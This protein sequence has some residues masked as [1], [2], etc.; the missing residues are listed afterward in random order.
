MARF[1][2]VSSIPAHAAFA[3]IALIGVMAFG[4]WEIAGTLRDPALH[5]IPATF[6]D[7]RKGITTAKV[8]R[9]IEKRLPSREV[10]AT[11]SSVMRYMLGRGGGSEV[12]VGRDG[13]LFLADELRFHVDADREIEGRMEVVAEIDRRLARRGIALVVALVPDKAR[14]YA[15]KLP[16]GVYPAHNEGRYAFALEKL[17]ARN[18]AVVDLLA[19]LAQARS[20]DVYYLTDTHW[21]A[22]GARIAAH[23]VADPVKAHR[24]DLPAASFKE[25]IGTEVERPG[26]LIRLMGLEHAPPM[27]RPASDREAPVTTQEAESGGEK[28]AL[29]GDNNVAVVLLGTSY[30][31]RANFHGFLQQALGTRVLD[32]AKDGAGFTQSAATYFA[33][34]AFRDAP[35]KVIVWEIPERVLV[36]QGDD[37]KPATILAPLLQ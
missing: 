34:E 18:V 19:P 11:T 8:E 15:G 7:I 20:E 1:D 29:F 25:T 17:R 16:N 26:D 24:L 3:A 10:L 22:R 4:A 5:D 21:N 33:N 36:P 23:S 12:V 2:S 6:S 35:P 28:D 31:R 30:S 13:W 32:A 14:V 27:L 9:E 37:A